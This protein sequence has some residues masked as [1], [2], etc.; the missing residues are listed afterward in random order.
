MTAECRGASDR[1]GTTA[2]TSTMAIIIAIQ[3]NATALRMISP[4][5]MPPMPHIR[6]CLM[7]G[8]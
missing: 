1:A 2:T 6:F 5:R 7:N 3:M 4:E 8:F